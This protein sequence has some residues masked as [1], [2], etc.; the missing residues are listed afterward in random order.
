MKHYDEPNPWFSFEMICLYL[1][2]AFV[3]GFLVGCLPA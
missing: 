3:S 2:V 1:A